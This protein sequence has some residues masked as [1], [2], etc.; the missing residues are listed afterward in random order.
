MTFRLMLNQTSYSGG[1]LFDPLGLE[2]RGALGGVW[3]AG[4]PGTT[5]ELGGSQVLQEVSVEEVGPLLV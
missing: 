1:D 4:D 5:E 3:L 2:E